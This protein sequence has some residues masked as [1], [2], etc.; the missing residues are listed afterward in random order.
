[1]NRLNKSMHTIRKK[2]LLYTNRKVSL[3]IKPHYICKLTK[4]I[5]VL[6]QDLKTWLKRLKNALMI[7]E[8]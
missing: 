2:M 5:Y 8:F 6:K 7:W 3:T 1:M 4:V